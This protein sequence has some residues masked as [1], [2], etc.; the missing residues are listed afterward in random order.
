MDPLFAFLLLKTEQDLGH[1]DIPMISAALKRLY[2]HMFSKT[3]T[4]PLDAKSFKKLEHIYV[5]LSLIVDESK[6]SEQFIAYER[7]FDMLA[8]EQNIRRIAFVGEAGVGKTTL[9]AKI[10]HDW[11]VGNHLKDIDILLFVPLREVQKGK[12]LPEL[13]QIYASRGLKFNVAKVEEYIKRNQRKCLL[14][15]DG[16]DEYKDDIAV[17]D[18]TNVLIS[19]MR[20]DKLKHTPV[21]ITTRPWRAEQV[22]SAPKMKLRYSRIAVKGFKKEDVKNYV[23]KFFD[24]D[25][26]SA[27]GLIQLM[28]EDSVVAENM[29][30]Y[31]IFCCML[32]NMWKEESRRGTILRLETF[33][34]LFEEMI[35][36][37]QEHWLAKTSFRDYRKRCNDS[38]RGI[39]KVAF[40]GLLNNKLVFTTDAFE[41]CKEAMRTGCEIG[42]LSFEKRFADI[43][44]DSQRDDVDISFPHKLFQEFLAG[45]YLQSLYLVDTAQFWRLVKEKVVPNFKNFKYLIY[46]TLFHGKKAGQGGKALMEYI[47]KE[48]HEQ[49]YVVD[50]AFE[51]HDVEALS[52]V[53]DYFRRECKDLRLTTRLQ[54]LQKHT[55]AGYMY[56]FEMCENARVRLIHNH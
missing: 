51:C 2:Q 45:I 8:N 28:T 54:L 33:S 5:N 29:A 24:H 31:P 3:K 10:A 9:L 11:A 44:D 18:P 34:Q 36:S 1:A 20:G 22:M 21:L 23:N 47:C 14:L 26:N 55:W 19:V 15:L 32:C 40:D 30:P 6:E 7:I 52:A 49:E 46:F 42:V 39:G 48:V 41:E 38:L 13:L 50:V 4:S 53:V 35:F 12:S 27:K 17:E 56:I 37:L 43:G 16:L 25:E